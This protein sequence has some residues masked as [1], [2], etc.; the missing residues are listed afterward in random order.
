MILA[1]LDRFELPASCDD[2]DADFAQAIHCNHWIEGE[3]YCL[4]RPPKCP[5]VCIDAMDEKSELMMDSAK[6]ICF[7]VISA[8]YQQS[9]DCINFKV[10]GYAK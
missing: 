8:S 1:K 2:C 10:G 9:D 3:Q 7:E 5:L 4:G 6:E